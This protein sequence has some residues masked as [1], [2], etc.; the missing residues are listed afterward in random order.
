MELW[1][2]N[3]YSLW[4]TEFIAALGIAMVLPFLPFYIR[5]LGLKDLQEVERSSGIIFATPYFLASLAGPLWGWLGDRYGRKMM[6]IRAVF[7][8][9][10]ITLLIGFVQ[11]V[12]Q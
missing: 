2:R 7:S 1:K 3:L 5:E 12:Q 9:A 6:L 11:N 10:V 8:F 4:A